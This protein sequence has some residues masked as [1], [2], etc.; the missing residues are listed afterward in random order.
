MITNDTYGGVM[1]APLAGEEGPL[2]VKGGDI[3]PAR[4]PTREYVSN[5]Q[6]LSWMRNPQVETRKGVH[7]LQE[8]G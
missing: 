1:E 8:D 7:E 2:E 5:R 3:F 6:S 4:R